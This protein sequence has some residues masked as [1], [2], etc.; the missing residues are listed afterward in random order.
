MR[1]GTVQTLEPLRDHQRL[2][3]GLLWGAFSAV[4][5]VVIGVGVLRLRHTSTSQYALEELRPLGTVPDFT[6][7]E[8]SGRGVTKNDLLGKVWIVAFIFTQCADECPLMSTRLARLQEAFSAEQ[9]LLLV[10]ITIDPERDTPAVLSQYANSF[11]AHPQRWLFLTGDKAAIL[12]LAREG[13]H[14][15]V[16]D[17]REAQQPLEI[18]S[19]S[20][21][22]QA[23]GRVL[24]LLGPPV[25]WAHHGVHSQDKAQQAILHSAR[26]VLVD[27][28]G[29]IRQYYDSRDED[30]MHRLQHHTKRLLQR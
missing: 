9:D 2:A 10:S 3:R 19:P 4:L 17:P 25:S 7:L 30:A 21:F 12:R 6:L 5:I 22:R 26:F 24:G 15:G 16:V 27:R 8:R 11:G 13:F 28:Q 14:L 20:P 23:L 18:P 1:L 29:Q